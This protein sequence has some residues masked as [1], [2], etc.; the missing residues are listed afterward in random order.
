MFWGHRQTYCC[1]YAGSSRDEESQQHT[2]FVPV[3]LWFYLMRHLELTVIE[4]TYAPMLISTIL[5]KLPTE[6]YRNLARAHS[7]EKWTLT[8]LRRCILQELR[9]LDMGAGY[10][11]APHWPTAS[12]T[13]SVDH[14]LTLK[15]QPA[16]KSCI[17][18]KSPSHTPSRCK[19]ITDAHKNQL[20]WSRNR[21]F[22]SII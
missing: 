12:F 6:V 16:K 1:T 9:I 10:S 7:T 22:I 2:G 11:T 15:Q 17:F 19:V 18:C 8:D 3:I 21:I 13:A 5:K 20:K 4:E 14:K